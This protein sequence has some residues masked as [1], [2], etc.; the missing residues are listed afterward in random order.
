MYNFLG[1]IMKKLALLLLLIPSLSLSAGIP[2][3]IDEIGGLTAPEKQAH[4]LELCQTQDNEHCRIIISILENVKQWPTMPWYKK[5]WNYKKRPMPQDITRM[6]LWAQ[7]TQLGC[8]NNWSAY[9]IHHE[10]TLLHAEYE[11]VNR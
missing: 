11:R 1:T 7:A 6:I 3:I 8:K 9:K 2:I 5:V 4:I 10:T